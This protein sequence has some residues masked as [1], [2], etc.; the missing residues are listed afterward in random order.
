MRRKSTIS[1]TSAASLRL[2]R[3]PLSVKR[4]I[5]A[6]VRFSR[7]LL[8]SSRPCP[9]LS[10]G[11][12]AIPSRPSGL[13]AGSNR[14]TLAPKFD[15]AVCLGR[16]EKRL[17]K[18][19]LA[20]TLKTTDAKD[21]SFAHGETHTPQPATARK[22]IDLQR[23]TLSGSR[24]CVRGRAGRDCDRSSESRSRHPLPHSHRAPRPFDRCGKSSADRRWRA[25]PPCD[26][27]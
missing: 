13:H 11:T 10:S 22:I 4:L 15:P 2:L 25:P 16:T 1:F 18:F 17:E 3:K 23:D 7:K 19:A 9:R 6:S 14:G 26:A 5:T 12:S 8:V 24:R 27:R 20:V 21:L